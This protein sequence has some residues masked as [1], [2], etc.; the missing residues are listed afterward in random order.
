MKQF[1]GQ[2]ECGAVW[3][4]ETTVQVG[5]KAAREPKSSSA[6]RAN[7]SDGEPNCRNSSLPLRLLVGVT[8]MHS[9]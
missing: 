5:P 1:V 9:C 6:S 3:M 7:S 4:V 2:F 8:T